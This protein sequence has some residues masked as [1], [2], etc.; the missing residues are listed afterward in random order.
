MKWRNIDYLGNMKLSRSSY[1]WVILIPVIVSIVQNIDNEINVVIA[2]KQFEFN[3][4]L[5]FKWYLLYMVGVLFGIG[6]LLY[7]LFCPYIIKTFKNYTEYI[8]SGY[9]P[10]F[11]IDQAEKLKFKSYKLSQ[12]EELFSI[13]SGNHSNFASLVASRPRDENSVQFESVSKELYDDLYNHANKSL[14][15]I[16]M[17]AIVS[18]MAGIL[19]L[20]FIFIKNSLFVFNYFNN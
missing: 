8:S 15:L 3:F 9:P 11:L 6:T 1:Y 18:Y 4:T 7:Q 2:Q 5:P 14:L 17:I 12:Y 19:I 20:I 16:R 10:T 13:L